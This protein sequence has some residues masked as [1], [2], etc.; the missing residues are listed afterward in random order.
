MG[1]LGVRAVWG[2]A[3]RGTRGVL[4]YR[5]RNRGIQVVGSAVV[6]QAHG[7]SAAYLAHRAGTGCGLFVRE[8]L[9]CVL[10]CVEPVLA[11]E[12]EQSQR[13]DVL[14]RTRVQKGTLRL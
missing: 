13:S 5:R 14:K 9:V 4:S 2:R 11:N 1:W 10:G 7:L 6:E 12:P 8:L 3:L